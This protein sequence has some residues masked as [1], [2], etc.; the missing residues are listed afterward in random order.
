M[1]A[2]D[3]IQY[4]P[5]KYTGEVLTSSSGTAGLVGTKVEILA[6]TNRPITKA[7]IE[8]NPRLRGDRIQAT[9]GTKELLISED[10]TKLNI[11][12]LLHSAAGRSAAVEYDS[13]RISVQDA[14]GQ[15]NSEPIIYPIRIVSDLPPEVAITMPFESPKD[16]PVD[17]QQVIE[18]HASDPDY[19]L[20]QV[21]LEIRSGLDV[22]AEPVLWKH[23]TGI[24][25]NQVVEYRFRPAEHEL[26]V[27]TKVQIQAI[28]TDNRE[29]SDSIKLEPNVSRSDPIE[30]KITTAS[31]L[32]DPNDPDAGGLSEQT[33]SC[34]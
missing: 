6:T 20:K 7:N 29:T 26:R 24:T 5:P 33:S 34:E 32:P 31:R 25:G 13:Y 19:G 17:A 16:V 27:G 4:Q 28:A 9:A 8:F 1:V 15:Q 2:V 18:V 11:A 30:I 14:A 21:H 10:G 12:F 3:S 23:P 22:I